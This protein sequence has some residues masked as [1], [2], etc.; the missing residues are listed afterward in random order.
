MKKTRIALRI[1]TREQIAA[2]LARQDPGPAPGLQE[3]IAAYLE[4]LARWNQ[5]ISLTAIRE[6]ELILERHFGEAF[7][8]VKT[9]P[10]VAG[11]LVD[12]GSGAGFPAIAIELLVPGLAVTLVESNRKKCAFLKELAQRLELVNV[13]VV[14]ERFE[15][16]QPEGFPA[17]FIT[18]RAV[19]QFEGL[20]AWSR[21][22]LKP[23]GKLVLWLGEKDA[24]RIS[25][26]KGWSWRAPLLI[27]NSRERLLLTGKPIP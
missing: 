17:D 21:Q 25:R 3:K 11:A 27:P 20:L 26:E 4:L 10:I 12:I 13:R 7:F 14:A 9:V 18:C 23:H 1:P 22:S 5:E 19:G 8:A 2:W 15:S 24:G 16:L 6:P